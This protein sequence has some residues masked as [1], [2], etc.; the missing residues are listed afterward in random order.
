MIPDRLCFLFFSYAKMLKLTHSLK[1]VFD[2]IDENIIKY[3]E[4]NLEEF[5]YNF[6]GNITY[7]WYM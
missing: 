2:T 7:S 6:Y 3:I 5:N 4:D 1:I